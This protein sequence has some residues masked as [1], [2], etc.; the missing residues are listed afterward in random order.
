MAHEE[1][2]LVYLARHAETAW[3]LSGQHTGLTDLPLTAGGEV[4]AQ[5][6]GAVL[7]RLSFAGIF[8][9]PLRR[10]MRTCELAG[11]GEKAE[12]LPELVEWD[13]G[14]YE[15]LRTLEIRS[16]RPGW[17]IF[18]DGAPG[19]ESPEQVAARADRVV[20]RVRAVSG[21]VLLFSSA[22]F[23]RALATRW[24]G[25][26]MLVARSLMLDT[27]SIS[28]LGYERNLERPVIQVWNDTHHLV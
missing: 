19:G 17:E 11:F 13:Y 14:E 25:I 24:V 9:S 27:A 3:S 8:T 2:P 21:N 16:K 22:H 1:L 20:E 4:R 6:L 26:D 15:G 18:R 7:S 5:K 10:A 28:V 12:I 23:L